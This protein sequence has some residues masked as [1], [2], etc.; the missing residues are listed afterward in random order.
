VRQVELGCDSQQT[1]FKIKNHSSKVI[2]PR[3]LPFPEFDPV[4]LPYLLSDDGRI[5]DTKLQEWLAQLPGLK[6]SQLFS[7]VKT[8][9]IDPAAHVLV[10]QRYPAPKGTKQLEELLLY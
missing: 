3:L 4:A 6:H 7:F 10:T 2:L 8:A 9:H 5:Y 1:L